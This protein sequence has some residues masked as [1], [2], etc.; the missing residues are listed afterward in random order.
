VVAETPPPQIVIVDLHYTASTSI[1]AVTTKVHRA[2]ADVESILEIQ[3]PATIYCEVDNRY[4]THPLK[5]ACS[6]YGCTPETIEP[7]AQQLKA[8]G[9]TVL[10]MVNKRATEADEEKARM[11]KELAQRREVI[12]AL[13][14]GE[15]PMEDPA[16]VNARAV[17]RRRENRADGDRE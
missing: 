2:Q 4:R 16:E 13:L 9:W 11:E 5:W 8:E 12:E 15:V 10:L 3:Q 6:V 1:G 17:E 14:R 7:I